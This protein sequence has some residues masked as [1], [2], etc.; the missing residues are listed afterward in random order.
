MTPDTI[1][2]LQFLDGRDLDQKFFF[3]E[4]DRGTEPRRRTQREQKSIE[5]PSISQ[6]M[7]RYRQIYRDGV[8]RSRFPIEHFRVLFVTSKNRPRVNNMVHTARTNIESLH[9]LFLFIT[10]EELLGDPLSAPWQT[11]RGEIV[12]LDENG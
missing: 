9:G 10:E 12:R 6:K 2:G 11:G 7:E 5:L 3:L 1:F 8:H 4:A